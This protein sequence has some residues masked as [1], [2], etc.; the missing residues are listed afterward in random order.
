MS[1]HESD[2]TRI[3]DV[4]HHQS[5]VVYTGEKNK[6]LTRINAISVWG[7]EDRCQDGHVCDCDVFAVVW[8]K[9]PKGRVAQSDVCENNVA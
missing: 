5:Q 1:S 7:F 8:V 3:R 4:S 2:A 6:M 9:C